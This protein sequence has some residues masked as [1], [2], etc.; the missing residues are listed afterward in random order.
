M[1]FSF[2]IPTYNR[3]DL[4]HSC[5]YDIYRR[6]TDV[7]EV[8]VMD[9]ASPEDMSDGLNWWMTNGM[10][11]IR[12]IRMKENVGF[13]RNSNAG[14][15]LATGEIVCLMSN[16][17]RIHKDVTGY[18]VGREKNLLYGGRLLDFDTGWN[19]FGHKLYPY[20]EGWFLMAHKDVWADV[21]Y[22]DELFVP[23]D[24]EDVDLSTTA[25]SKGYGLC[26]LPDDYLTHLGAQTIQYGEER[27]KQTKINREKFKEKWITNLKSS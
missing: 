6:C 17:V 3:Y 5:L 10:L 11:N 7:S 20:L 4:V 18:C 1:K 15:K 26:P 14:L 24:Y 22:F 25:I 8:I 19:K 12:H 9:N 27:E 16:D 23:N 2:V 13:L 21:G